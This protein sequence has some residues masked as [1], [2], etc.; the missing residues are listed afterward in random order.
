MKAYLRSVRLA[1]KKANLIALLVRG[2]PVNDALHLLQRTHK[3]G[4]RLVEELL[5][6]AIANA[7]HNDKQNRA[8]L[9]VKTIIVNQGQALRRGTPM[10]RG[11]MRPLSKFLS[12]IDL[13]LGIKDVDSVKSA[14][15]KKAAK[16]AP[17]S[18]K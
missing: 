1:P 11:R 16:K 17:S 15:K 13:V 2:M 10:A 7:E 9:I 3:K 4:A 8:D 6:S 14:P 12:H 5:K 18:T